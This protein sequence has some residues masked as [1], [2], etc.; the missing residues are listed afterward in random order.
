MPTVR[1]AA[2]VTDANESMADTSS[3]SAVP[4]MPARS[5]ASTSRSG[6]LGQRRERPREVEREALEVGRVVALGQL[7]HQVLEREQ[8]PGVDLEGEVEVERAAAAL[9]GVQV[10]LPR[11]AQRV[12]LDEVPLVVHVEP[13]VDH[14]VL[15]LGDESGDVDDRHSAAPF[16]SQPGAS[17][18]RLP[19]PGR[20]RRPRSRRRCRRSSPPPPPRSAGPRR[21]RRL[22]PGRHGPRPAPQRP[23]GRRRRGR[24]AAGGR[25]RACSARR[26]AATTPSAPVTVV[27]DPL[28]GSTN[29]SRG[30]PWFATSLC[31]V[32]AD[33]PRRRPRRRPRARHPL[34]RRCGARGAERDGAPIRSVGRRPSSPRRSS[35]LNGLPDHHFGWAQFRALGAAALDLCAVADGPARRLRRLHRRRSRARGTTSAGCSCAARRGRR[36]GRCGV[37]S[38]WSIE[39]GARRTR[40]GRP[41]PTEL[42]DR[43]GRGTNRAEDRA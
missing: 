11:L 30:V 8:H 9:L 43:A 14:V 18:L 20:D 40:G 41:R 7:H 27:V 15:Q 26:A 31:A 17:T 35:A 34:P 1:S 2:S 36:W 12:R 25:A 28:D 32:D 24:G 37:A 5:V 16:A 23:R 39:H 38:S 13:V 6:P 19:S 4:P 42:A 10:D 3:G 33:G 21:R 22:G 29:A